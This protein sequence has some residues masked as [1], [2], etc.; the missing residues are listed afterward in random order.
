MP[1][2]SPES[3]LKRPVLPTSAR[4]HQLYDEHLLGMPNVE[5][6]FVGHKRTR[7]RWTREIALICAVREKRPAG[8][9]GKTDLLP[10]NVAWSRN[11][12]EDVRVAT[13]VQVIG[14]S[15]FQAGPVAGPGDRVAGVTFPQGPSLA[16]VATLGIAMRHP[17]FGMVITTAGHAVQGGPGTVTFPAGQRPLVRVQNAGGGAGADFTGAVVR[18]V[19]VEEADYALLLPTDDTPV[20][21]L[22]QDTDSL[23][24]L[25]IP[26]PP[27]VGKPFF[28]LKAGGIQPTR[29]RG[30]F[31]VLTIDGF[32]LRDLILTDRVTDSGDSG[33]VLIDPSFRVCGMLVGFT[34][35]EGKPCSVFMSAFWALKMEDGELF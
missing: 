10:E 32:R 7:G 14:E 19:R 31:G 11:S 26:E 13:D 17:R 12:Q 5:G 30:V 22:Y 35:V 29:L 25:Y 3:R 21:N 23:A 33:C 16:I 9:L 34:T 8:E 15:A 28:A 27:D 18:S 6:C 24:G 2:R 1:K 20:R 4:V